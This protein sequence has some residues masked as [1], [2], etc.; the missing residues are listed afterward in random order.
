MLE[1]WISLI[2]KN[3]ILFIEKRGYEPDTLYVSE[4]M[5]YGIGF[6]YILGMNVKYSSFLEFTQVVMCRLLDFHTPN[7]Q[8]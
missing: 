3:R 2:E 4:H 6:M 5:Y 8:I 1:E 7:V